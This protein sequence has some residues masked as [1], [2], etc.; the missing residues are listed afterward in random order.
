MLFPEHLLYAQDAALHSRAS[1]EKIKTW[2]A[3]K[4]QSCAPPPGCLLP[5]P[6]GGFSCPPWGPLRLSKIPASLVFD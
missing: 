3:G 5:E 2:K 4:W 6:V 1:G